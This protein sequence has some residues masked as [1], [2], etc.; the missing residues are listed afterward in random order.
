[1]KLK[2]L[3][4][5]SIFVSSFM[6]GC[7]SEE[8]INNPPID[9]DPDS[10][11]VEGYKL[12]WNDEFNIDGQ[13]DESKWDYDI[14][15]PGWVNDELQYYTS[16]SVNVRVNNGKLEI[17]VQYYPNP[18]P[19]YTSARIVSREKGDWKYGR[20]EVKA[21][22][23][24]GIT[25][26][27]EAVWEDARGNWDTAHGIVQRM[28]TIDAMVNLRAKQNQ[29]RKTF[30]IDAK[31]ST[32]SDMFAIGIVEPLVVKEQII[33]SATEAACMILRIDDIIAVSS[34]GGRPGGPPPM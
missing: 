25:K 12:V 28:D 7:N 34:G 1:M 16:D 31:K 18:V 26:E 6:L 10:V 9:S 19:Q 20:V 4:I 33:K 8:S 27:L 3:I 5:F 11:K 17:E 23:P 13:P 21:K 14:K 29:G 22:L 32:I 2:T 30:G 24:A 15:D